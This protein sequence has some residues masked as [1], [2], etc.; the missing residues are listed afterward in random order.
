MIYYTADQHFGHSNVILFCD[1]PFKNVIEMD[2]TLINNWNNV[3]SDDDIVY[4]YERRSV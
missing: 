3:V 4:I 1:R 2:E